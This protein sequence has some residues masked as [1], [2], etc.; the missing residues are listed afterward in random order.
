MTTRI[1]TAHLPQ[2]LVDERLRETRAAL[3]DVD[4]GRV[5]QHTEVQAWAAGLSLAVLPHP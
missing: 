2:E 5:V 3:E 4:S 1:E